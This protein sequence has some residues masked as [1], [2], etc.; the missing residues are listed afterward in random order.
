MDLIRGSL[1]GQ[2]ALMHLLVAYVCILIHRRLRTYPLLQQTLWISA[3][4]VL[5]FILC[6][7]I[8]STRQPVA[9]DWRYFAP[10][11]TSLLLWPWIFSVLRLA[12]Q[13]T[14]PV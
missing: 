11:A 1:L 2:Y 6:L 4:L 7:S 8:D 10:A 3:L 5:Y 9:M 12:K 13:K 14:E